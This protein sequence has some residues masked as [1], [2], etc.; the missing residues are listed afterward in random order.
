MTEQEFIQLLDRFEKGLCT[1][2]EQFRLEQWLDSMKEEGIPFKTPA[3]KGLTK[4]ALHKSVYEKARI[5]R[6]KSR[7]LLPSTW[8]K[9]A[10]AIVILLLASYSLIK[11]DFLEV[12]RQDIATETQARN[13]IR[14]ILLS[15]GSIVWL[16]PGSK[17]SYPGT[18]AGS[19]R[20]VS[21]AGEA[22]F[23][24]SKNPE[25]PFIIHTGDLTTTVLGTSF[26]I[27]NTFDHTEVYVLTGK[28]LVTLTKSD[29]KIEVLPNE[30]VMYSHASMKLKKEDGVIETKQ[31]TE[32]IKGTEYNMYFQDAKV[33]DIASRIEGKFSVKVSVKGSIQSCVITADFTDQSLNNTLDM[34]CEA[35]NATYDID[36]N[37]VTLK[38]DG[39]K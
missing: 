35:L 14:K 13:E 4:A 34:I 39:C 18:F 10:A 24:I 11:F 19:E 26:N 32:Y 38:G 21:L 1:P 33:S 25:R 23:E 29:Q 20:V 12:D 5:F 36:D 7:S 2:E 27:K 9:V 8:M 17:L 6:R 31:A 30:K 22:V 15:D 16:K 37:E 28:V 3:E